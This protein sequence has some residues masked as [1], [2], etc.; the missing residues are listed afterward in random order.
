MNVNHCGIDSTK[1]LF[2]QG[3]YPPLNSETEEPCGPFGPFEDVV[4]PVRKAVSDRR[5]EKGQSGLAR[6]CRVPVR[7]SVRKALNND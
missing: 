3:L 4:P 7:D 5:N 1:A 2:C 6:C